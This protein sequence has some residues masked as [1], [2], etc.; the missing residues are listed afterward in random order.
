M[1]SYR[2]LVTEARQMLRSEIVELLQQNLRQEEETARIAERSAPELL[3]KARQTEE[4][5]L[6]DKARDKLQGR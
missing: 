2:S 5:S 1:G 6:I 4:K 3:Q